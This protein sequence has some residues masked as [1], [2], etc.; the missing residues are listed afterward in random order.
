MKVSAV[1]FDYGQTHRQELDAATAVASRLGLSHSIVDVSFYR[2]LAA[3]SSLTQPHTLAMPSDR[4]AAEMAD[5]IPSTYV[6]LRNTF[7]LT[8]AAAWLESK[9]LAEI[10]INGVAPSNLK[11]T[12]VI[13]ANAIDYSGY[14]DCRPE[15][16]TAITKSLRLGS[17]LGTQY[18]V[19]FTIATPL[20][21]KSKADIV[22]LAG[23]LN[24]PIDATWS[25][26]AA[27]KSPC[28]HCD[29]CLLRARGFAEAGIDDPALISAYE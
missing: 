17:K 20:I 29:S 21:D 15:F 25:C 9:A 19:P 10:E 14:P 11:A 6:P 28:G 23:S 13:A 24:A 22:R 27:G 18:G 1:S 12:L 26:Y 2:D 5:G 8:M 3:Y 16:Y 4:S 7:F